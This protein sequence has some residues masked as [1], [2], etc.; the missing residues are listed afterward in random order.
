MSGKV[1]RSQYAK[2]A[3]V[4]RRF[5]GHEAKPVQEV[6]APIAPRAAAV[7]GYCDALLYTTVRDGNV[8]KYKHSFAA[9]DRPLLCVGPNKKVFLLGGNYRF[10]ELGI[11]DSSDRKHAGAK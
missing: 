4:Y 6:P 3:D 10:T 8:E 7:I 11:V 1:P 9:K 5:T 2:V